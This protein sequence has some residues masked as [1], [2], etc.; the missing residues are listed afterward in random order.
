MEKLNLISVL[1]VS[2]HSVMKDYLVHM[3][4]VTFRLLQTHGKLVLRKLQL[5]FSA[6]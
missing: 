6:L 2:E 5:I 4:I 1:T 3:N